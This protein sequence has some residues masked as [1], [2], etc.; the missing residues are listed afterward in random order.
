MKKETNRN[1]LTWS[2][3]N[4]GRSTTRKKSSWPF[5]SHASRAKAL[6]S[7][8]PETRTAKRKAKTAKA[9]RK[10]VKAWALVYAESG[11]IGDNFDG[12]MAVFTHR[13]RAEDA[14]ET[15]ARLSDISVRVVPCEITW[16]VP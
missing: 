6:A 8:K 15:N 9:K 3:H 4:H 10:S 12:K 14:R 13:P 7:V 16:R 5:L 1:H 2:I 11:D